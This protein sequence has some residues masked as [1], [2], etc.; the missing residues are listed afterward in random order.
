MKKLIIL[1]IVALT[2]TGCGRID[3]WFA[4]ITGNATEECVDGVLYLQFTSGASVAYSK[5]G[6]IKTCS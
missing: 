5:D 2:L 6:K 1:S 4:G 3:R